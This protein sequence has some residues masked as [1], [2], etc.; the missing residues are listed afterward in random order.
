LG[1]GTH[2]LGLLALE[3]LGNRALAAQSLSEVG[4]PRDHAAVARAG[5][6]TKITALQHHGA[7][8][9]AAKLKRGRQPTVASTHNRDIG[10]SRRILRQRIVGPQRFPPP[11]LRLEV[12]MKNV[13][14]GSHVDS[15]A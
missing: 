10:L 14:A 5:T 13:P 15:V 11:R 9:V 12:A 6:T 8:A 7:D 2:Q 4:A 1:A 3:L